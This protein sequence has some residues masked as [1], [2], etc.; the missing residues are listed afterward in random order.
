MTLRERRFIQCDVFSPIPARGNGLAVV[1]DGD[2]LDDTEMQAF[3]AW[4]NLA[5]T[6]FLLPPDAARADYRVRIFSTRTE[7]PFA[8][9]PTLGSCAAWLHAGGVPREPGT[10]RQQC[11]IGIVEIDVTA[12]AKPAFIAPPTAMR[13]LADDGLQRLA[14]ALEL[15]PDAIVASA[16][17]DNGPVFQVL[18]LAD[19][20]A[21]LAVDSARVRYPAF[22]RIGLLGAHAAAAECDY[23]SRLLA[24]MNGMSEDP[25]TGSLNSALAHWL[26]SRGLLERSLVIAQGTQIGRHGRVMVTPR[27]D[28][29][30][31]IGGQTHVLIDGTVLL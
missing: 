28:G 12:P 23:E 8:G 3:A 11:N 6:T 19:A 13:P 22:S 17:L 5:E 15:A 26:Q 18:Q 25:I 7:M 14:D 2:G 1:V 30:I 20:A 24:P 9:H 16:E 10:V 31:A 27:P 29:E 4:T 21:V